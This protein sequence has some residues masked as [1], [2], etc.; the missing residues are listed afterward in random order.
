MV[1]PWTPPPSKGTGLERNRSTQKRNHKQGVDERCCRPFD[2]GGEWRCCLVCRLQ[3]ACRALPE[4]FL[5]VADGHV[6]NHRTAAVA[7]HIW[8]KNILSEGLYHVTY[9]TRS[10]RLT[11]QQR[12]ERLTPQ[13]HHRS[14]ESAGNEKNWHHPCHFGNNQLSCGLPAVQCFATRCAIENPELLGSSSPRGQL[15]RSRTSRGIRRGHSW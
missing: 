13:V 5:I 9:G 4:L 15:D 3:T 14:I 8:V 7:C 6:I 2:H 10:S 12:I 1:L 11:H